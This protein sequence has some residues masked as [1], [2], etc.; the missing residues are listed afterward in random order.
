MQYGK[1]STLGWGYKRL[2]SRMI[3][4]SD[5]KLTNLWSRLVSGRNITSHMIPAV[6]ASHLPARIHKTGGGI[7]IVLRDSLKCE[8]RLRFQTKSQLNFLY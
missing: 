1:E 8:T 2:T 5:S 6:Y 7:G 4:V 3:C